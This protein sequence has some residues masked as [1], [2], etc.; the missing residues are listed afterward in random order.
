[1][2]AL[3]SMGRGLTISQKYVS[4][5]MPCIIGAGNMGAALLEG[6]LLSGILENKPLIVE[7]TPSEHVR[8]MVQ[9][10][11]LVNKKHISGLSSY[12]EDGYDVLFVLAVKPHIAPSVLSLLSQEIKTMTSRGI[13]CSVLSVMAGV[14][15]QTLGA[16][17]GD[18]SI[19]RSMPNLPCLVKKGVTAMY[20]HRL[21]P[22][23]KNTCTQMM[24]AI[25][26]TVWLNEESDIHSVTALS[27]SGPAYIFY[28]IECLVK[29]AVLSGLEYDIAL[30]MI[31]ETL[32][33]SAILLEESNQSP[34]EWRKAVTSPNGVTE[35]ALAVLQQ[36]DMKKLIEHETMDAT[37]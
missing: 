22:V 4:L 13:S 25:G 34:Q 7:P 9:T 16:S 10:H 32:L 20:G 15:L 37:I 2:G 35:A 31:K 26:A 30:K 14:S 1:M 28:L 5:P 8:K 21:S 19:I 18:M 24:S 6:W 29:A 36:G 11:S 3:G 23:I 33:G 12:I 17:L 27:G